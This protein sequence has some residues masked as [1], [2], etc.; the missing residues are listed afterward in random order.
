MSYIFYCIL[1]S[2]HKATPCI[3]TLSFYGMNYADSLS[4]LNNEYQLSLMQLLQ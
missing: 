1:Q 4:H 2:H 3:V